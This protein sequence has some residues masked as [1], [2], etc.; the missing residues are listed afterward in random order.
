[1]FIKI[2]EKL[3]SITIWLGFINDDYFLWSYFSTDLIEI[4]KNIT[5]LECFII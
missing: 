2:R 3:L 5:I 4:S 1:M